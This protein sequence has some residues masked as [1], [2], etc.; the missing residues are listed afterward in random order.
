MLKVHRNSKG[1]TLIEL[2]IVIAIIGILAA[3][4][5]P[6]YTVDT[7]KSKVAGVIHTMGAIKNAAVAYYSESQAIPNAAD[8]AAVNTSYGISVDTKYA[9]Y[10]VNNTGGGGQVTATLANIGSSE[11]TKKLYLNTTDFKAWGWAADAGLESYVPKN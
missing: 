10:M 11:N 1:F 2:L 4:A 3:I 8:A 6:A 5:I 7:K 9:T